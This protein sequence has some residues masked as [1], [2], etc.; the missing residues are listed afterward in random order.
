MQRLTRISLAAA[1]FLLISAS[2][3]AY[4]PGGPVLFVLEGAFIQ[5]TDYTYTIT[6]TPETPPSDVSVTM[7]TPTS[8]EW[9]EFR[10]QEIT[11]LSQTWN[12]EPDATVHETDSWGNEWG[13]ATWSGVSG[14]VESVTRAH[15]REETQFGPIVTWDNAHT[16][17]QYRFPENV[18]PWLEPDG[19]GFIQSDAPEIEQLASDLSSGVA[20]QIDVVGRILAWVQDNVRMAQCDEFIAQSD[21]V[22][23]LENRFGNCV[24]FAHL[25]VALIRAAGIPAVPVSGVV[26]D[27][28]NP[29]V[30]HAWVAVYFT[31]LGWFEF[32]SSPWMP[33]YGEVPETILTPQHI[34][35]GVGDAPG[36]SNAPFSESHECTLDVVE[37][38]RELGFVSTTIWPGDAVTWVIGVRSQ[39]F[40]E[41]YEW[42]YGYRDLPVSLTLDGVPAGWR[43]S[44]SATDL[45]IRKQD[46]GGSP[47]RSVLLTVRAP[48]MVEAGTQGVMTVTARDTALAGSPVIGT[49]TA[50]VTIRSP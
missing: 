23:T 38:P 46:V 44:L 50:A 42:D 48:S 45:L 20:F 6:A 8:R 14:T 39:S 43:A 27:S 29:P 5:E 16:G 10:T 24:N 21:A 26:A 7:L 22:W 40:Y 11:N 37:K 18:R 30:G 25:T 13:T 12:P 9:R 2:A 1:I 49:L 19:Q 32:E 34:T 47:A 36:I 35:L 4:E 3:S 15:C 41:I 31:D 33:A 28:E 17:S